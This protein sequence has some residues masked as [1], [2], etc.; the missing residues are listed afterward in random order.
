MF[1]ANFSGHNKIRGEY[2]KFSGALPQMRPRGYGRD[3]KACVHCRNLESIFFLGR[4]QALAYGVGWPLCHDHPL[5][6]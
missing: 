1:K 4:L 5:K 2:K 6:P 3:A